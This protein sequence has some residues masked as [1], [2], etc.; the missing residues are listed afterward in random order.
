MNRKRS[1]V[2][3]YE[4]Y[5]KRGEAKVSKTVKKK[6][7]A[8]LLNVIAPVDLQFTHTGM[9]IGE[10]MAKGY[11]IVRYSPD[12]APGWIS[13]ITNLP[14]SIVSITYEPIDSETMIEVLDSNINVAKKKRN[15]CKEAVRRESGR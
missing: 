9:Q 12:N 6:E 3:L 2:D 7:N 15:R 5:I 14:N 11:G 4:S 8:G 10:N 1:R 13:R